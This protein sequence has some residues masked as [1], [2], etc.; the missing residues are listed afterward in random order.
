MSLLHTVFYDF[1]LLYRR[2]LRDV[3]D[4]YALP[5]VGFD[6]VPARRQYGK[7][8]IPDEAVVNRHPLRSAF[9]HAFRLVNVDMIDQFL[10]KRT[11]ERLHLKKAPDRVHEGFLAE[12]QI[13][14]FGKVFP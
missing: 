2:D 13:V 6:V 10:Q 1:V 9:A 14:G 5:G 8:N 4:G 3:F 11:G 7:F 12:F